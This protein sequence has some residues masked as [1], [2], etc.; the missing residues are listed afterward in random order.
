MRSPRGRV[1]RNTAHESPPTP[2]ASRRHSGRSLSGHATSSF[3][4]V[5]LTMRHLA[6]VVA[7]AAVLS[8]APTTATAG[9][10]LIP[11]TVPRAYVGPS[12]SEFSGPA[13]AGNNVLWLRP[14]RRGY[15][16]VTQPL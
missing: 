14:T 3:P 9:G 11:T 10:T 1:V 5:F 16:F 12:P 13:L 4:Q 6:A 15:D 2:R 8:A 7:A